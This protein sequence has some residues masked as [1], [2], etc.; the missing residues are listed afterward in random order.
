M[1]KQMTEDD[2]KKL[3]FYLGTG[4]TPGEAAQRLGRSKSTVVR[5]IVKRAVPCLRGYRSTNRLCAKFDECTRI[6]GYGGNP[7]RLFRCTPGCFE[8]CPEFVERHCERLEV[9][10]RVC[11]GCEQFRS[12]P[13]K[14]RIYD[15][16]GAQAN[17]ESLL[18]ESRRG[19]HPGE[20][21]LAAMDAALTH[22]LRQGQSIRHVVAANPEVFASVKERTLYDYVNGGLFTAKR[23]DLPEACSRRPRR[24]K[25]LTK[26]N[27]KCRVGRT[28]R[29]FLEHCRLN[30]IADWVE[31]DT[32]VGR[33]GGKVLF[34]LWLPGGLM[35]A[36]LRKRRDSRTATRLFRAL[37]RLAGPELFQRLFSVIL[38]DNGPEFSDPDG[39]EQP[40]PALGP[41]DR[42]VKLFY[43]DPYCSSQKPR[44]ERV[45]RDARRVL[46]HGVSFDLLDQKDINLVA[47]HVNSYTRGV[48]GGRCAWDEFAGRC[49]EEGLRFLERL[50]LRR[51]PAND[52]VLDPLLLGEAFKRRTEETVLRK[53]G[54]TPDAKTADRK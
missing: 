17:R 25:R 45:H 10:S 5:E 31:L 38:T 13:L 28:Y 35:L 53:H 48:L 20:E 9:P 47:S 33:V 16:S 12:C 44:I 52:V 22:G 37:R 2:R 23:F 21:E 6:K 4:L 11:N 34:T 36:F 8:A 24:K 27:A 1:A 15:A 3:D 43:A 32:V 18:H 41:S 42:P 46:E 14:K 29:E 39:I 49:G 50:G 54:I 7:K 30:G 51:I 19:V 26:T 40:V